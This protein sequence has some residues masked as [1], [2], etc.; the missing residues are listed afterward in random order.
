MTSTDI[1][2][3]KQ[4]WKT[5]RIENQ[6]PITCFLATSHADVDE[7]LLRMIR[8]DRSFVVVGRSACANV[9]GEDDALYYAT[10]VFMSQ[11]PAYEIPVVEAVDSIPTGLKYEEIPDAQ[12]RVYF[13][14]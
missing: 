5:T 7:D 9:R 3:Q 13:S 4:Y 10:G 6:K 1:A 12:V 14:E 2:E 11:D 8:G